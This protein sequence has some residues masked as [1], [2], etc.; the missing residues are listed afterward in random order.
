MLNFTTLIVTFVFLWKSALTEPGIIPSLQGI[1]RVPFEFHNVKKADSKQD[2]FVQYKDIHELERSLNEKIPEEN[3][4]EK[5]YNI[6]KYKYCDEKEKTGEESAPVCLLSYCHTCKH[7]RPPRAFHCSTCDVC[8]EAHDHHCPWV[9]TCIGP[10][11]IQ[12]FNIFLL[13]AGLHS[14][15]LFIITM[16]F[17]RKYNHEVKIL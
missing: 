9:G 17:N 1:K 2:V 15:T 8:I 14:L 12:D 10:R 7:I 3:Y 5:L 13:F 16:V 4:L 6:D 11:N